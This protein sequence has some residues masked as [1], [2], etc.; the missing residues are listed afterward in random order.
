MSKAEKNEA[1]KKGQT[2]RFAMNHKNGV[3]R[4]KG[5]VR[6]LPPRGAQRGAA[7]LTV[8]RADGTVCRPYPSQCKAA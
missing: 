8:V 6:A 3:I 7:R 5:V 2:V 4:G 1:M